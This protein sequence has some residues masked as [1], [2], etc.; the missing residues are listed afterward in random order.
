M[1]SVTLHGQEVEAT[2]FTLEP[3]LYA[4]LEVHV[5]LQTSV[6]GELLPTRRAVLQPDLGVDD[7]LVI[8][9]SFP[10]SKCLLTVTAHK[11]FLSCMEPH[12]V[13]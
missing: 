9:Q 13:L 8:L 1:S 3:L 11:R 12:V 4:V 5:T 2:E 6:G 10:S 7:V